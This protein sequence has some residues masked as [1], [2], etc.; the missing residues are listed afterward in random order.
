M[1]S[2]SVFPYCSSGEKMANK[3]KALW[4]EHVAVVKMKVH[5]SVAISQLRWKASGPGV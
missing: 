2:L 4:Y 5:C 3:R 1:R